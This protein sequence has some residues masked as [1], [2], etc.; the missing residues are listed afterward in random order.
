[1]VSQPADGYVALPTES[2]EIDNANHD[3]ASESLLER[4]RGSSRSTP[5]GGSVTVHADGQGYSYSYGPSGLSGLLNNYYALGCSVFASIGGA[6]F[7]Y[8]QGVIA[9]ILVMKNFTERWPIGAWEKGL[10]SASTISR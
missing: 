4:R 5:Y 3:L 10:M 9:N 6:A 2:T 7:G 1:M 8:E